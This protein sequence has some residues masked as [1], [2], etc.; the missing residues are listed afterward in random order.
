MRLTAGAAECGGSLRALPRFVV[1]RLQVNLGVRPPIASRA[2]GVA[3]ALRRLLPGAIM[4]GRHGTSVEIS[5]PSEAQMSGTLATFG[6]AMWRLDPVLKTLGALGVVVTLAGQVALGQQLSC[7]GGDFF[8]DSAGG[9]MISLEFERSASSQWLLTHARL[10]QRAANPR[11]RISLRGVEFDV[12]IDA[13]PADFHGRIVQNDRG[14]VGEWRSTGANVPLRI[15]CQVID[16]GGPDSSSHTGRFVTVAPEVQLEVLDW[17]GSGRP[18]IL[19]HGMGESAHEFDA[20]APKLAADYHVF[21]VTR[22]GAGRSSAPD[23]GY[24]ANQ[25]GDDVLAVM[26]SL[27]I[28]RPVLVGHS[29]GGAELSS[30]ASRYPERVAGLVYLD[31]AMGYAY[32]DPSLPDQFA[33]GMQCPCS[34]VEKLN[35]GMTAYRSIHAPVLAIYAMNAGDDGRQADAFERGVAG[36]RVVRIPNADHYVFRSNEAEVLREMRAFI[37][38]LPDSSRRPN[39]R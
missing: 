31:A 35:K 32:L 36:S 9:H 10:D 27:R 6:S 34:Y 20:F 21:G 15:P 1:I 24:S 25:L 8:R 17:G 16:P 39:D 22:R 29:Y 12:R 33:H 38:S 30:V 13:I 14:I 28:V 11:A 3:F 23:T 18:L 7:S 5:E 2:R 37:N 4:Y 26:D 19:I